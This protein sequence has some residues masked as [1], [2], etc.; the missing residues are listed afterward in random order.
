MVTARFRKGEDGYLI[1]CEG[2]ATGDP[3]VCAGV[4]GIMSVLS[5][6]AGDHDESDGR[7]YAWV[8]C[9]AEIVV[10]AVLHTM[11]RMEHTYPELVKVDC[12]F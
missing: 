11:Q 10:R 4:S 2:H 9:D 6:V 12:G 3:V 5:A 1:L 8:S 7:Y